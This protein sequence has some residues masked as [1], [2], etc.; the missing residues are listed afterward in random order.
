LFVIENV[1]EKEI[2][3]FIREKYEKQ[4]IFNDRKYTLLF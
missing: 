1:E 3:K 4:G 2:K